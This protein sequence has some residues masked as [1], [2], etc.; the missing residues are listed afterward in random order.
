[1]K[2]LTG[3]RG[4][5]LCGAPAD[6]GVPSVRAKVPAE[7]LSSEVLADFFIG[8]RKEQCFFT[9]HRCRQCGML[10]NPR[11]FTD[12]ALGYLY[13][14]MPE[15]VGVS[16]ERDSARTQAGYARI[17][18]IAQASNVDYLELGADVGFLAR[19][20]VR[21]R[22]VRSADAVEPNLDVHNE[23]LANLGPV[24][25]IYT[26]LIEVSSDPRYDVV[27]AIHVLDHLLE[28]KRTLL[29]IADRL[30]DEGRLLIVVHDESSLLRKTLGRKWAPFCLQHPQLFRSETLMRLLTSCGYQVSA[31]VKTTNWLSL[32]QAGALAASVGF[33]PSGFS[34]IL[35]DL[36]VPL[37][38][39]NVAVLA[40]RGQL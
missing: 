22:G 5:P 29:G 37:K 2:E 16:G 27:T 24:G 30:R 4:C 18:D 10:W 36:S 14:R 12:E 21:T 28:P 17:L 7:G 9:Y 6:S 39:G 23:L 31:Q 11:Y 40:I 3:H 32:R 20:V 35:P 26:D 19:E 15:N 13:S 33:L 1:M 34:K 38:L 8:F 25:R